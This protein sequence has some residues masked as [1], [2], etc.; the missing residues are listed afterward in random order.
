MNG[1]MRFSIPGA[2]GGTREDTEP[3]GEWDQDGGY[4]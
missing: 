2:C 4:S 1:W 3:S